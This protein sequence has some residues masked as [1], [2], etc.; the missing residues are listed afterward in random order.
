MD[1][2]PRCDECAYSIGHEVSSG[3]YVCRRYPKTEM[4]TADMWCGEWRDEEY[5]AVVNLPCV[6]TVTGGEESL[7]PDTTYTYDPNHTVGV[8]PPKKKRGRPRKSGT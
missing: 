6:W 5:G 2:E 1:K 3:I 7:P 4:K 8:D